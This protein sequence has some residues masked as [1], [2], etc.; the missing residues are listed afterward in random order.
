MFL[1]AL[2]KDIQQLPW[3]SIPILYDQPVTRV[4]SLH[5]LLAKVNKINLYKNVGSF[6]NN[7]VCNVMLPISEDPVV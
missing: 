1:F 3:E 6:L 5:F 2:I 4:P 7:S